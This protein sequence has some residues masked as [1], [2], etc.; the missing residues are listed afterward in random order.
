MSTA[1]TR[2]WSSVAGSSPSLAKMDPTWVSTVFG[3]RNSR[4]Q[5][6]WFER[7]SAIRARISCSRPVRSPR[8]L[9]SPAAEQ[10]GHY[11]RVDDRSAAGDPPDG[12]GELRDV[13]HAVFEQVADTGRRVVKQLDR[14]P[15]L[16]VLGQDQDANAGMLGADPLRREEPV[17]GVGRRHPDVGDHNVGLV[18][19][20]Q[21]AERVS[22]TCL[23]HNE[24]AVVGQDP[25]QPFSE[26]HGVVGQHNP[27]RRGRRE[28]RR[29]GSKHRRPVRHR[30]VSRRRRESRLRAESR[31]G[32]CPVLR[33]HGPPVRA[34]RSRGLDRRRRCHRQPPRRAR[35]R[36][37][38]T[39]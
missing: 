34:A 24:E 8:A 25:G 35:S 14:L 33:R 20:D 37:S 10:L 30:R 31:R 12:A 36:G 23:P 3:D 9:P 11:V 5:M 13:G 29:T 28:G 22:V 6:A 16:H 21:R 38:A 15:R 17:V 32:S 2:R 39:G 19:C 27:D 1:R 4:S 26:E 18:P 7:P